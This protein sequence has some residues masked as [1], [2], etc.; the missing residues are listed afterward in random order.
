MAKNVLLVDDDEPF[1]YLMRRIINSESRSQI[2]VLHCEN[3]KLAL[4]HIADCLRRKSWSEIP[5]II[6]L[7][8]N[9]PVM[10]GFEF[11]DEV[12]ILF[13]EANHLVPPPTIYLLSSS[14]LDS[15]RAKAEKFK[16]V[17]KYLVKPLAKAQVGKILREVS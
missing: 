17:S 3:G 6:F 16:I 10:S 5:D 1:V 4:D 8:I 13:E 2:Q 15:D 9:M 14:S 11:L 12:S 7:D